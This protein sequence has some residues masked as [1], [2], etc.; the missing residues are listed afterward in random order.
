[1]NVPLPTPEEL[2]TFQRLYEHRFGVQLSER[3]ALEKALAVLAIAKYLRD[4]AL[5]S[6]RQK[7]Q[8]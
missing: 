8:R 4:N 3:E 5:F 1:M 7:K 2:A 6:L